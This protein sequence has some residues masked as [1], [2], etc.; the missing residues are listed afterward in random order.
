MT[1]S[2]TTRFVAW[3]TLASFFS[4][5]VSGAA[6][7]IAN[8]PLVSMSTKL[9]RPN[10][11]FILD[12]SSSMTWDYMPDS[13]N[14][15]NT[16]PCFR[17]FGYNK[18]Y[19]NPNNDYPLPKSG[20]GDAD[21]GY[22]PTITSARED[23]YN[24]S[25]TVDNLNTTTTTQTFASD[26]TLTSTSF[27]ATTGSTL[28]TVTKSS[29]GLTSGQSVRFRGISSGNLRGIPWNTIIWTSGN[30][31][32]WVINVTG[33]NTFTF[34]AS[35]PATSAG[36]GG[37]SSAT[38]SRLT[39][40]TTTGD[41]YYYTHAT[42]PSS[43][44]SD[45]NY[46][47]VEI[48]LQSAAM[49]AKFARWYSFYRTRLNMM[50][51]ASGR[52]FVGVDD[53]FRVGFTTI[54]EKS[55]T[56]ARWLGNA[57]F[58]STQKSSWYSKLYGTTIPG[59]QYTPLRG[60]LSKAGRYY[61][62][63]FVTGDNDPVQY[64]CQKN[65]AILTTD[66]YWNT[67]DETA[68]YGPKR[69]DNATNVG[70]QDSNL[71]ESPRPM[72]DSG[73][74]SNT[75]A[76][77]S[78]YYYKTDLR[79]TTADGGL[80]D[81]GTRSAV[82]ANIKDENGDDLPDGHQHM[83]TLTLGLGVPGTLA[84]PSSLDGLTSG[85]INWPDPNVTSSSTSVTE[86]LDDLWHAAIN[87]GGTF[88]S[89]SDPEDVADAIR[90]ALATIGD[91]ERSGAA[92]ATSSLE[93]VAGDNFAYI[94]QYAT[95]RW[96]GDIE[97]HTI[98]IDPLSATYGQISDD[99]AW[100]AQ[101]EL[102][103][104]VAASSDTRTIYTSDASGDRV[105]FVIGNVNPADFSAS[106]LSQYAGWNAT[107]Q[108]LATAGALVKYLR[109]QHGYE[110]RNDDSHTVPNNRLFRQRGITRLE[111][112]VSVTPNEV[113]GDI[114]DTS[115]VYVQKPPFR[116]SDSGYASYVG[117]QSGRPGTVYVGA[118]DGMLH[119]FNADTGEERWAYVPRMLHNQLYKLADAAY[120]SNHRYF[121][122]G[123]ITVGDA[124]DGSSWRTIL[125]GGLGAGGSGYFALDITDADDPTVLWEYTN[126]N[127]GKTF[128][129]PI[130]T[131]RNSSGDWVVLF[132]SGYNNNS[133]GGDSK[134]RLFMVNAFTGAD[135]DDVETGTTADPNLSGI[136]KI[137][138]WV[139]DTLVDN[140]TT[141]VYGGDLAGNLWRFNID[142]MTA[143]K[144]GQTSGTA[145]ARPITARPEVSRIRDQVGNYH[146]VVY[147]GTGRYMGADD[148]TGG[149]TAEMTEQIMLAVKDTGTNLG[150]LT[151]DSDMV[152]QTLDSGATPRTIPDPQPVNWTSD[153]GWY[154]TIPEGERVT[155]EPRL[156]LGT[157][158]FVANYPE[159]DYCALGG[160]SWLYALDYKS[161]GPISTQ[162]DEVV[163][164]QVDDNTISTGLTIVRLP[165]GTLVAIVNT[166]EGTRTIELPID[167]AGAGTVRRVGYREIN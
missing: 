85:S 110:M 109:G 27:A 67:S 115:P 26:V 140:T 71:T 143:Q 103:D 19:F 166:P 79:T 83:K 45:G 149:S 53:K 46:T 101:E 74:R 15:N 99:D 40:T 114:I 92:A 120:S 84:Y 14:S 148:V 113:L 88:A 18:V 146:R 87:G 161:G 33:T 29:H 132:A 152:E 98:D 30:P 42:N 3:L 138:N 165:D 38:Y 81:D 153:H 54:S 64:S 28:V 49:K 25:S 5:T 56:A 124:Y 86:R 10:V 50:K 89:A 80:R 122:N 154:V 145:G 43:C 35:T 147:V 95:A 12:D 123:P 127:L 105:D 62:G 82:N 41:Y 119:A 17:N 66:G 78:R 1:P 22:S 164:M 106:S 158:S 77:I 96:S 65:F 90:L 107:Q 37:G 130:L 34:N 52:A 16:R 100:S 163:G 156:Q 72:Y 133:G 13:V 159:D 8:V 157:V 94:A 4:S 137:T 36:T 160:S 162:A 61:A 91:K 141:Y 51:S 93:P 75:L 24:S 167:A 32:T 58:D 125:I 73:A 6:V 112:G 39:S 55:T 48:Y 70:D 20:V 108:G 68:T 57:K 63:T 118:N 111:G 150:D 2:R 128:G 104:E 121:V 135:I 11:M 21:Y 44:D 97:A 76:D 31:L 47:K 69:A 117:A 155:I 60:A 151:A 139:L 131:K 59:I 116:Y 126:A 129:N 9:V 142:A 144:L 7:D 134:G 136:A 102:K 23:G